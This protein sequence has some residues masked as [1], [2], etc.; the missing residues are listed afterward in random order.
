M[1]KINHINILLD[2][3]M[4]ENW[5]INSKQYVSEKRTVVQIIRV[6]YA[7]D[8][9]ARGLRLSRRHASFMEASS[10]FL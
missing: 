5:P 7:S 8:K 3:S 1:E 6:L 10:F 9:P 4:D 2:L